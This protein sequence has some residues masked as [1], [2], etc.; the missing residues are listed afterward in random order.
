MSAQKDAVA[1]QKRV[2]RMKKVVGQGSNTSDVVAE[3]QKT[4]VDL[5]AMSPKKKIPLIRKQDYTPIPYNRPKLTKD[6][7]E[8]EIHNYF[9]SLVEHLPRK[10]GCE[11]IDVK[12]NFEHIHKFIDF[13][14]TYQELPRKKNGSIDCQKIVEER[15]SNRLKIVRPDIFIQISKKTCIFILSV[16]ILDMYKTK[17]KKMGELKQVKPRNPTNIFYK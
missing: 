6:S 10:V 7:T 12:L 16:N 17:Q 15:G 3:L 8:E 9:L 2:I 5:K 1:L 4:I 11:H 13:Q 14:K